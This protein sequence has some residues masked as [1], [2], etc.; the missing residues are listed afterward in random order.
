M[1]QVNVLG[2]CRVERSRAALFAITTGGMLAKSQHARG[3]LDSRE[4]TLQQERQS[5]RRPD[6]NMN[7]ALKVNAQVAITQAI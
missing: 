5:L 4:L 2:T 6:C 1:K 3:G 7:T